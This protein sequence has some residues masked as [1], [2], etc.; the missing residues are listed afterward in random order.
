[1]ARTLLAAWL[2]AGAFLES[3]L[4]ISPP[5][6]IS[7]VGVDLLKSYEGEFFF[8][9]FLPLF[10]PPP[11]TCILPDAPCDDEPGFKPDFYMDE[12]NVTTIGYG[13]ACKPIEICNTL[14]GRRADGTTYTLTAPLSMDQ[15]LDLFRN[16]LAGFESCVNNLVTA[17]VNEN[18]YAALV[19]FT[20]N[21]GCGTLGSSSL[22][23]IV[24]A[25]P[26]M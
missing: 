17:K 20:F 1:M 9:W 12:V 23:T 6:R 25:N 5:M 4:A 21:E 10:Q 19:V 14:T 11:L 3:A 13:H 22:L 24:N 16:D 7:K 26:S 8:R 2:L 15:A 18:M